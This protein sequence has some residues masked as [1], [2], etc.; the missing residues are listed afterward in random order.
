M[1]IVNYLASKE[2]KQEL[3]KAFQSLDSNGDGK[4]SKDELIM[5]NLPPHFLGYSKI[6]SSNAQAEA[7]VNKILE[8]VDKNKS[9]EIDYS[10]WVMATINRENLLSK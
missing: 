6:Y 4:L 5:G 1:F 3:L 10:E 7:E 8:A 9:G 2:E